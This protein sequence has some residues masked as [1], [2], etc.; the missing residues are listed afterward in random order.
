MRK[1]HFKSIKTR[2]SDSVNILHSVLIKRSLHPN[3][4][5]NTVVTL[6]FE[7]INKKVQFQSSLNK[8]LQLMSINYKLRV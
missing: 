4:T 5:L 3:I 1:I 7:E 2:G 6:R 8:E